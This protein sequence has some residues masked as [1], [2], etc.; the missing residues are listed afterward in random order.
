MT[1]PRAS[2][3]NDDTE[4]EQQQRESAGT[5]RVASDWLHSEFHA[6]GHVITPHGT[7]VPADDLPALR[8]AADSAG[9]A[10][11]YTETPEEN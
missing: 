7:D 3:R 5:V 9:V 1:R 2:Q 11:T 10:L 4:S 6:F 8:A